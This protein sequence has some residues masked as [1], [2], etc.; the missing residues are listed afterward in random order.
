[1]KQVSF[2]IFEIRRLGSP[3]EEELAACAISRSEQ[4]MTFDI[5]SPCY[6]TLIEK[7]HHWR[8]EMG[9]ETARGPVADALRSTAESGARRCNCG[10]RKINM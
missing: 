6:R 1:M 10:G 3:S 8:A 2:S 5:L 7:Y 9:A 4:R